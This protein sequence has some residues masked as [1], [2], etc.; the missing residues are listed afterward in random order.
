VEHGDSGKYY[1]SASHKLERLCQGGT[2]EWW[3]GLDTKIQL[4]IGISAVVVVA[5]IVTGVVLLTGGGNSPEIEPKLSETT[6]TASRD[7]TPATEDAPTVVPAT[8]T[9]KKPTP[10]SESEPA[11]HVFGALRGIRDESGG[12]WQDLWVDIDTADFLTGNA[13]LTYLTSQGDQDYYDPDYWYVRDEGV[14]ITSFKISPGGAGAVDITM[15][16]YPV[17]PAIGFYGPSMTPQHVSFG[18]FYDAIYMDEDS[19]HLLGRH[20]WFTVEEGRLVAIEE[21]PRDPYY[22][23]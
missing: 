2:M 7:A 3:R 1:V 19:S 16:T 5:G 13:A 17:M 6:L 9:E 21:Q 15:Y 14:A 12:T 4:A 22:E 23:P 20:Y 10:P 18:Q 8:P 11:D